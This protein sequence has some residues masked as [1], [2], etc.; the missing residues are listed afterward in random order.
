MTA[1]PATRA[2]PRAV[3]GRQ[4]TR[5]TLGRTIGPVTAMSIPVTMTAARQLHP[6]ADSEGKLAAS[7]SV[8]AASAG[9]MAAAM[10]VA[11]ARCLAVNPSPKERPMTPTSDADSLMIPAVPSAENYP[12]RAMS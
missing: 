5:S 12:R 10:P 11:A 1:A 9:V 2:D 3:A 6:P 4:E 8:V 7:R